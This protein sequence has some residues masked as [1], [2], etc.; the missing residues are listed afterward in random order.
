MTSQSELFV[1]VPIREY[2]ALYQISD[3]GNVKSTKRGANLKQCER[4]GYKSVCL[5]HN[6]IKRN[7]LV[8][9]LVAMAFI[10]N[11]KQCNIVNHK[12]GNRENNTV[13]NLEW[14]TASDN[15]LHS[16]RTLN[17]HRSTVAVRQ[18]SHDGKVIATFPSIK[19]AAESTETSAKKIPSVCNGS[20]KQT[21]GFKWEYVTHTLVDVPDGK[22]PLGYP[23]YIIT[24]NGDVY[25]LKT[26]RYLTL[27]HHQSGYVSVGLSNGSKKDFYVHVLVATLFL[28]PVLGKDYVNHKD[29]NKKNNQVE[30]L[31]WVSASENNTHMTKTGANTYK[32]GVIKCNLNGL[33]LERYEKVKDASTKSKVDASSIVRVCK[34]K[35]KSAGGFFWRYI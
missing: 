20:R 34:G 11:P 27:N 21:G 14:V 2:S 31:E 22:E 8:H 9:R 1:Q 16:V 28:D 13:S 19:E 33:E 5:S 23:G 4:N 24:R 35:Q 17:N 3:V 18:L 26:R 25:S 6:N 32:R 10:E 29:R 7:Y 30:N 12:D 15:A